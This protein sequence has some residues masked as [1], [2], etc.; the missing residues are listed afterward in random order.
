MIMGTWCNHVD[1]GGVG[2][3]IDSKHLQ[4]AKVNVLIMCFF[5]NVS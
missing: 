1:G 4:E 5:Y 2:F 3:V